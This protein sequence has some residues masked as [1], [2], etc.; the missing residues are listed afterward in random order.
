M[1]SVR[2]KLRQVYLPAEMGEMRHWLDC[3][4]YEPTSFACYQ[5][6][7][8]IFICIEFRSEEA[9]AAFAKRFNGE[10]RPSLAFISPQPTADSEETGR[11][12]Q[13]RRSSSRYPR[14]EHRSVR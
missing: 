2:L 8:E 1:R 10:I 12:R 3:N 11:K 6:N 7:D 4:R 13:R 14:Q 5:E 9:A